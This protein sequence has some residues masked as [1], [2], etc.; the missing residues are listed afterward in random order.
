MSKSLFDF[1]NESPNLNSMFDKSLIA[2]TGLMLSIKA[3]VLLDDDKFEEM[4]AGL[5][6]SGKATSDPSQQTHVILDKLIEDIL[7]LTRIARKELYQQV[8]HG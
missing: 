5:D 4:V 3:I 1:T 7:D 8:N 2:A 6:V